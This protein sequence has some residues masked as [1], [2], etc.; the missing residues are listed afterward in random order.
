MG[1]TSEAWHSKLRGLMT[2]G[3]RSFWLRGSEVLAA[4][5]S[6]L[7]QPLTQAV[8]CLNGCLLAFVYTMHLALTLS[9]ASLPASPSHELLES[10]VTS[11]HLPTK[12]AASE[13]KY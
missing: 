10:K 5:S 11:L 9:I 3:A 4:Q 2:G 12:A 6:K 13:Q 1:V 7:E 8:E